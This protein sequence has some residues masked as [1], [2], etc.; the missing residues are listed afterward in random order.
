MSPVEISLLSPYIEVTLVSQSPVTQFVK[1]GRF[2]TLGSLRKRN[3][4]IFYSDARQTTFL[5]TIDT[6]IDDA[7]PTKLPGPKSPPSPA[8][9]ERVE[10]IALSDDVELNQLTT[11]NTLALLTDISPLVIEVTL[12]T[13]NNSTTME[14]NRFE[15]MKTLIDPAAALRWNG[16]DDVTCQ[17]QKSQPFWLPEAPVRITLDVMGGDYRVRIVVVCGD[18]KKEFERVSCRTSGLEMKKMVGKSLKVDWRRV[19]LWKDE[20]NEEGGTTE[21]RQMNTKK[22]GTSE[23][24]HLSHHRTML[25][26]DNISSLRHHTHIDLTCSISSNTTSVVISHEL[27]TPTFLVPSSLPIRD[28]HVALIA[29]CPFVDLQRYHIPLLFVDGRFH[30][31]FS[32]LPIGFV[33]DSP[34]LNVTVHDP[35]EKTL[36][37]TVSVQG[38]REQISVPLVWLHSLLV[39]FLESRDLDTEHYIRSFVIFDSEARPFGTHSALDIHVE[40]DR[41]VPMNDPKAIESGSTARFVDGQEEDSEADGGEDGWDDEL[42]STSDD[43]NDADQV[44]GQ[45]EE[46]APEG[47][48]GQKNNAPIAPK[49]PVQQPFTNVSLRIVKVRAICRLSGAMDTTV[50]CILPFVRSHFVTIRDSFDQILQ[51]RLAVFLS[52]P[53]Y[54]LDVHV[55][56]MRRTGRTKFESTRVE[57]VDVLADVEVRSDMIEVSVEVV[58]GLMECREMEGTLKKTHISRHLRAEINP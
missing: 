30:F 54:L 25:T 48:N 10:S 1:F 9:D 55:L 53:H 26:D 42:A 51:E 47:E 27:K 3:S 35:F 57:T 43:E 17:H 24:A 12:R 38:R 11:G 23:G 56:K 13:N 40:T 6:I 50:E 21:P 36:V 44:V 34:I 45:S 33:Y 5:K 41:S 52:K 31:Q 58:S 8:T 2:E 37:D 4:E 28:V 32:T 16:K 22:E 20:Q 18:V 15:K 46:E 29:P 19:R 14:M 39:K 49:Y 7:E